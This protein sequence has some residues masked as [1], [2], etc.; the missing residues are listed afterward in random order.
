MDL[1]RDEPLLGIQ[2]TWGQGE[3]EPPKTA[4]TVLS[5]RKAINAKMNEDWKNK[6]D[7]ENE[8]GSIGPPLVL[9][10]RHHGGRKSLEDMR[11]VSFTH[12]RRPQ[13]EIVFSGGIKF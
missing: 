8:D 9:E 3:G 6:K 1:V 12:G 13:M 10:D 11:K 2:W 7:K 5:L 4:D